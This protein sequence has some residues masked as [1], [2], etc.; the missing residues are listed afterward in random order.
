[1]EK[2]KLR[3]DNTAFKGFCFVSFFGNFRTVWLLDSFQKLMIFE[4]LPH[5]GGLYAKQDVHKSQPLR[6][7]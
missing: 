7:S 3:L 5:L 4:D 1:M 2:K 6:N